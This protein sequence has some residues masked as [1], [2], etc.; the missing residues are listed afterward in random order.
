[1]R[2]VVW[3]AEQKAALKAVPMAEKMAALMAVQ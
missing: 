2:K 3:M 1:V